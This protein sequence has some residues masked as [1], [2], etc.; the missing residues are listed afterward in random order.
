MSDK[1]KTKAQ[2]VNEL[3]QMRQRVSELEDLTVKYQHQETELKMQAE[4]N[5]R[6][7]IESLHQASNILSSSLNYA[8]VL[9]YT[10]EQL[11]QFIPHNA[12][13][14][15]LA[16][17]DAAQIFRWRGSGRPALRLPCLLPRPACGPAGSFGWLFCRL[18]V[19]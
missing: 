11:G 18:R 17:G 8:T 12:A 13:C 5:Q 15:M 16:E 14:I 6:Q 19:R 1:H 2:L 3:A 7:L 9:D 4:G 10:L